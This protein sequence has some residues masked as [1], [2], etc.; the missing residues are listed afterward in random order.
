M[1][2]QLALLSF[3]AVSLQDAPSPTTGATSLRRPNVVLILA[4]DLGAG[5]LGAYGQQKIRTPHLDQLAREGMRFDAAYSGSPVCAPSR[6]VLLTGRHSG[7]AVV[8]DNWENGGWGPDEPEGQYPL[9]A[10]EV[11]LAEHLR[12]AGYATCAGGKWGLGGPGTE[13]APNAQGFDHFIGYLCQRVAHNYYPTHLWRDGERM[14]LAG[15][16]AWFSA[17]Q[18]LT[19]P[20]EDADAYYERYSR[21]EYA[22]TII[23]DDLVAWTREYAQGDAPFFLY[24]PSVIP[25]VALQ[26]PR[27][28]VEAYPAEWDEAAYLG[29]KSYLPH[30][31]PRRAYAAMITHLDAAVGRILAALDEAGVADNTLVIFTSDNGA[32]WVG[33]VDTEFFNSHDGRRGRKAQL[34]EGGI[35][36]PMIVRWP[37]QVAPGS[38][39]SAPVAF[40]DLFPTIAAATGT[41]VTDPAVAARLDGVDLTPT[42]RDAAVAPERDALYFEFRPFGGQAVRAGDW[43]LIRRV[44]GKQEVVTLEL[45]NLAQDPGETRNLAE[46]EPEVVARLLGL[47]A[48]E[49]T[50]SE[51]FPLPGVDP[52]P[53][54]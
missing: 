2:L 3:A 6:C 36:V 32:T 25:H 18:K 19:A 24:Y 39:T 29:D 52:T 47:M 17:H 26:A 44:Q 30:A 22:P 5:E 10:A 4:D 35:R 45:Y 42:L 53:P 31:S 49:H 51:P 9:P 7:R 16:A 23:A 41:P 38:A 50:P 43:K 13:G 14:E 37:G 8:R 46:A 12:A 20:L 21:T 33:G 54:R 48:R 11:T 28:E 40:Q 1:M 27:E 15:N 34:Y